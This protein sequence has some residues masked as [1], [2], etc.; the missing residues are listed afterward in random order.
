MKAGCWR[1]YGRVIALAI[2]PATF[3]F[4]IVFAQDTGQTACLQSLSFDDPSPA[5][6]FFQPSKDGQSDLSSVLSD[7]AD[8]DDS[9]N[10]PAAICNSPVELPNLFCPAFY[11]AIRPAKLSKLITPFPSRAPPVCLA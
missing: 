6:L 4:S 1:K 7:D 10:S 11:S 3:L 9:S 5:P 8:N 2:L